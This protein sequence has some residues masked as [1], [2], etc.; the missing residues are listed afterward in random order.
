MLPPGGLGDVVGTVPLPTT[1]AKNGRTAVFGPCGGQGGISRFW[2]AQKR[3]F[4]FTK[5]ATAATPKHPRWHRCPGLAVPRLFGPFGP[6]APPGPGL[7][8]HPTRFCLPENAQIRTFSDAFL[9]FP[10]HTPPFRAKLCRFALTFRCASNAP[11]GG[12][13]GPR[14]CENWGSE[15]WAL[16]APWALGDVPIFG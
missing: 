14:G 12:L 13:W 4:A 2:H 8:P 6:W 3:F 9:S 7:G 5:A 10:P 16:W 1:W 11:H 15:F